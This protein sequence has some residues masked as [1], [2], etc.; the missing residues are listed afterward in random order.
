MLIT[1][2]QRSEEPGKD[3]AVMFL[4]QDMASPLS[5]G[6]KVIDAE[7]SLLGSIFFS[8]GMVTQVKSRWKIWHFL[9]LLCSPARSLGFTIFGE[10]IAYVTIF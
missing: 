9:L 5:A 6:W 4:K 2:L 3:E 10:I 8:S 1:G 7:S